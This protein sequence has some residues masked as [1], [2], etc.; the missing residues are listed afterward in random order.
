M[1][2]VKKEIKRVA[3]EESRG[4]EDGN[5]NVKELQGFGNGYKK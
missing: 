5:D 4:K 1:K 3:S 2:P